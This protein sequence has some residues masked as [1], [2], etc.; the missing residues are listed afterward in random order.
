MQYPSRYLP[1]FNMFKGMDILRL[2]Q[3]A[4]GKQMNLTAPDCSAIST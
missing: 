3:N 1:K 4:P 2:A